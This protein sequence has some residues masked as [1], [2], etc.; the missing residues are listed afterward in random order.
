MKSEAYSIF[1][2]HN[3][4]SLIKP[5]K[6]FVWNNFAAE[7]VDATQS[8]RLHCAA[9]KCALEVPLQKVDYFGYNSPAALGYYYLR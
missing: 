5:G 9:E 2:A 7:L 8:N 1:I 4:S 6:Y 3:K